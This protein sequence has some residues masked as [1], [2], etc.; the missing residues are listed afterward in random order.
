MSPTLNV[1][2]PFICHTL[3]YI[4]CKVAITVAYLVIVIEP[5]SKYDP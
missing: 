2:L 1:D 3:Y 4:I 5:N